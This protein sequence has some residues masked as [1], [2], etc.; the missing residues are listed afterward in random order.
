MPSALPDASA[1][2]VS[3]KVRVPVAFAAAVAPVNVITWVAVVSPARVRP[4]GAPPDVRDSAEYADCDAV[5]GSLYVTVTLS[6]AVTL[7]E[8]RRG[9]MPS[10]TACEATDPSALPDASVKSTVPV[11]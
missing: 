6:A 2:R 10:A 5:T 7:A 1:S 11:A 4:V 3:F 8:R 9:T